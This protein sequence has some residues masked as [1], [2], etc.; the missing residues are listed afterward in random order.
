MQVDR[1]PRF[2][3]KQDQAKAHLDDSFGFS[4]HADEE[5]E[6]KESSSSSSKEEVRWSLVDG[7]KRQNSMPPVKKRASSLANRPDAQSSNSS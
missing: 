4:D 5:E 1:V 7:Y 6:K 3:S 2:N